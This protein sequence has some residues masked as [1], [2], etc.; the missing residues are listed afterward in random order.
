M[1]GNGENHG[2]HTTMRVHSPD[3]HAAQ[4]GV[5]AMD[6]NSATHGYHTTMRLRMLAGAL[7]NKAR[8]HGP[9][10]A[11]HGPDTGMRA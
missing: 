4:Q 8:Q 9:R 7:H 6:H 1:D 5:P 11:V 3:K 2:L 10:T